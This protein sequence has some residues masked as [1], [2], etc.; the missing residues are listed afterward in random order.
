[1]NIRTGP[2]FG[3]LE[4]A[5]KKWIFVVLAVAALAGGFAWY[6]LRPVEVVKTE[7]TAAVTRGNIVQKITASGR[8]VPNL[9]VEIK[10]KASGEIVNLPVEEGDRVK[11]GDLLL[12]LDPT[13]EH[14]T[15]NQARTSLASSQARLKIAEE[16]LKVN[17][18]ALATE[19]EKAKIALA[20]AQSLSRDA[21]AKAARTRE[22]LQR[23]L[24]SA[25]EAESAET[26]A[27]QARSDIETSK[28][29]EAELDAKEKALELD[30]QEIEAAKANVESDKLALEIADQRVKNTRVFAPLGGV[31]TQRSVQAGQ[32]ISSPMSNVGGGTTIMIISDLDRIF[33]L[34]SVDEADIGLVK[35]GQK[36]VLRVDAFPGEKF[37]GVVQRISPRGVNTSNVVTF[38]VKIEVVSKNKEMLKPEM[39]ASADIIIETREN[40]LGIPSEA[41]FRKN[42]SE[43]VT[44]QLP[45]GNEDRP[46]TTGISDG[47]LTQ[48]VSGLSEGDTAII[49]KPQTD[50]KWQGGA[51]RMP[52]GGRH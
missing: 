26:Q 36:A 51:P 29:R 33:V 27:A 2:F 16:N 49:Q 4:I 18:R 9:D 30:K 35:E 42:G 6:K 10:C 17:E 14:R 38:E 47:Q 1:L 24:A 25:E 28:L 13:D 46:V 39:T 52:F 15:L 21:E 43:Y 12:E 3:L 11:K 34:A 32:I 40:V 20:S 45:T 50:S 5:L 44:V 41:V 8:V 31:V 19:R 22:L 48:I 7:K 37:Q 23:K